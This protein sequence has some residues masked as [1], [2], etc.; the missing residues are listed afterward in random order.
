MDRKFQII[1][2]LLL[3]TILIVQILILQRMPLTYGELRKLR[4]KD[5][6]NLR[7]K[8]PVVRVYGT[9]DVSGDVEVTNTPLEVEISQ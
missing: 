4:A 1:V 9:V 8:L 2:C 7:L 3:A 6:R 5:R